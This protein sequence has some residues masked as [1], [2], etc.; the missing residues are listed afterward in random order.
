[1]YEIFEK[2]LQKHGVTAYR[3]AKDTGL[4]TAT[5]TSW[6]QGKY[7]PK[8]EKLQKIADY[9][10]VPLEYLMGEE[11]KGQAVTSKETYPDVQTEEKLTEEEILTMA[12]HQV[13]YEGDLTEEDLIRIKLAMKIALNKNIN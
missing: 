1:M 5:I 8:R 7:T 12:A 6:K 11:S 2:L 3:V 10:D 4:T 9:F 13:G